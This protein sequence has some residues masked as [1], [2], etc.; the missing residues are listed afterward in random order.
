MIRLS[1]LFLAGLL[2]TA[3]L[4]TAQGAGKTNPPKGKQAKQAPKAHRNV[5][6]KL[7]CAVMGSP[8][9][10]EKKAAGFSD[11]KGT[12][13]YFCCGGC[14]PAFD[15]NPAKYAKAATPPK[16][17]AA[18]PASDAPTSLKVGKYVVEL[19]PPEDGVFA[20]EELDIEFGVF[21]STKKE[22]DGGLA[23]VPDVAAKAV[24]TM[25][26]MEGM[27]EQRPNIHQEGR[28]GVQGL[29][30]FFP[31]GG[32]YQIDLTL[33]PKGGQPLKTSFKVN[34][35]D[36]RPADATRKAPYELQVVDFPAH[37]MPGEPVDLKL[38]VVDTKTGEPVRKFDVAHEKEFHLLIASKDLTQFMHEHPEMEADG[39]W[40]YRATFPAG[41][42][43]WVYGDVAPAG[44]GSRI[45][46]QK[47]AVHGDPPKGAG[48]AATNRGPFTHEGL[49]GRIEP[50][51][52]PIPIG[53]MTTIR[54]RLTDAA[55]G[56][57]VGDTEPYL[58][59]AG[60]LMIIHEDG[61]TVV[62]SHPKHDAETD[63]LVKKGEVLFTGRFPKAGKYIAYAQF[64]RGGK[65]KTLGFALEVK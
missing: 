38:R 32:E 59:A 7:V 22:K 62:H 42:D 35:K 64:Q 11:Y 23:G 20:G 31:H 12:R 46:V 18:A 56:K 9:A 39:T 28:A 4:A 3:P 36:E 16:A 43:W 57:P 47:I 25:P 54:V 24:V 45:L 41:G 8:I 26:S 52:S 21:D 65:I 14:K 10:S 5:A 44:K 48:M 40:I 1:G 58:G 30:V 29:E 61:S 53:K 17:A 33:T 51:E 27:P 60:H 6:G 2:A 50:L 49:M 15:K 34:V 13:Y 19:W 37:A 63:A 55:T